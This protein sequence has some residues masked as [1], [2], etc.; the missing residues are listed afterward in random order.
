MT[1]QAWRGRPA[2]QRIMARTLV[3]LS[4]LATLAWTGLPLT[5]AWAQS[6]PTETA[7][8]ARAPGAPIVASRL[9]ADERL[10]LDGGLD[11]PAWQ[12]AAVHRQF[13][14]KFPVTGAMPAHATEVRVLFDDQALY[15]GVRCDDPDATRIRA[16]LV[17]HDGVNRTQDFV[18]AY[19]DAIGSR[20]SAQFFRVN[21]AGSMADGM[22]TAADDSED[23]AP[24]F[25]WDAATR[26]DAR[27]WT[28]VLRIPFGSLRF[29]GR[30][31]GPWRFMLARRVPREQFHLHTSVLVPRD[32]P[33]FI[34]ALQPLLGVALPADA[35]FVTVRPGLTWRR[36]VDRPGDG[37]RRVEQ[38]TE[39]SLDL[40]WRPLPELVVD[41]TLNPDFS[42]VA[43]DVP[44]LRG[45][46]RYALYFDEKRPF[47]FESSDLWRSPSEAL[48]SR[49]ITEP[50]WGLR[51]TWRGARLAGTAYAA[52]DRGG[53]LVLLPDAYGTGAAQQPAS[54]AVVARVRGDAGALQWGALA[55]AR[56]Y[57][58]GRGQNQV[59]GTDIGWQIDQAWRLRAQWLQS[60][61]TAQPG[62]DGQLAE[63]AATRGHRAHARLWYQTP[64]READLWLNDVGSHYRNDL[65]FTPQN[66]VR[67]VGGRWG[68]GWHG[69]GPFNDFW[70][71]L[72]ASMSRDRQS[73]QRVSLDWH[74]NVWLT[75]PH[76]L[77]AWLQWHGGSTQRLASDQ[78]L[79]R[80][81]YWR[82]SVTFT[83]APWVPFLTADAQW[84]RLVDVA[85][86]QVRP[87]GSASLSLTTR[88][89][90]QL[91][92]EPR[93]SMLWL[94][95]GGAHRYREQA[96]QVIA[97]WH[98]N[99][100][101]SLRAIV[102]VAASDRVAEPATMGRGAIAAVDESATVGSLTWAWR[103]SSGTVF[104]LGA[105]RQRQQAGSLAR[106]N[107][108][109]A[110]L[111]L[112][113]GELRQRLAW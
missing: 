19:V 97:R 6:L 56:R 50:R 64:Q 88:P 78:P 98:F 113:V 4:T 80:E 86:R 94:R 32:S 54:D 24:D 3:T 74:P 96:H 83:P 72:E 75:G 18:V 69:L 104:Y 31:D 112:D 41:A 76:N 52:A 5:A 70:V 102:Q 105:T 109:F 77:E 27:G 42:Q 1:D 10:P 28:A 46:T 92:L 55:T 39:A 79:L 22:H 11:H 100:Q 95:E 48:Y 16:P 34:A 38:A 44:Q 13:T 99:A 62:V 61:T 26:R 7:M 91:D 60:H 37:S 45:N 63:G 67:Q 21:A 29:T 111:Q 33:S 84:G 103:Q 57:D 106:G 12:R 89:L 17:R 30:H 47:F 53:G 93:L 36:S 71:N 59:A 101:H 23:F 49:S 2:R 66:G 90:P 8:A 15:I 58:Q 35:A 65:G 14:E 81:R 87:G 51:S 107:E 85:A 73:G 110:K 108:V 43:L 68:E 25:D 9:L 20:Q 40:K 82:G